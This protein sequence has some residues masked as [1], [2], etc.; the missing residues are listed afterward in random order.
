MDIG[1]ATPEA[2]SMHV[3]HPSDGDS[4]VVSEIL[5][6]TGLRFVSGALSGSM[7]KRSA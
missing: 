1:Y 5:G 3:K 6:P 7:P 2:N 4:T